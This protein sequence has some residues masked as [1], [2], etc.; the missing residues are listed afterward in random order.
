MSSFVLSRARRSRLGAALG[1]LAIGLSLTSPMIT[2][3]AAAAAPAVPDAVADPATALKLAHQ[4]N[5]QILVT[6]QTTDASETVANPDGSW[7]LTAH[8]EP[9]RM[10]QNGDWVPLDATLVQRPDGAIAPKALPL[11][12]VLNPGGAGSAS[13][14]IVRVG[15]GDKQA[16]LTWPADLPTPQ[17]SGDTATYAD[18]YPGVDLRVQVT[19]RGYNEN[20]VVKTAAAAQSSALAGVTFGL[21]TRNTTVSVNDGGLTVKD[22]AGNVLFSGDASSM[23][24]SSGAGTEAEKNLGLGG[25]N[26]HA[27][28]AVT[29]TVNAVTV[30]PDRAFLADPS[31]R[32]PVVLD[33]E[34]SCDSCVAQAHVVVQSGYPGQKNYNQTAQDL[35]NL[36]AGFESDDIA[37]V[38]RSYFEVNTSQLAGA[39]IHSAVVNTTLLHSAVCSVTDNDATGLWLSGAISPEPPGHLRPPRP[40]N[41]DWCWAF[42]P[43]T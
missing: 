34:T 28:M 14:P 24:D 25:G 29:A 9:V 22:N 26:R 15:L 6:S 31:T 10:Q 32:F 27:K 33:P 19:T 43:A 1:V 41:Q 42:P 40:G 36:K 8:S 7:T 35:S 23:W 13:K 11:D 2:A 4:A 16:G 37:A 38:S 5:K 3:P 21:F 17:V 18:V 12:V 20:L 30:V 39:V